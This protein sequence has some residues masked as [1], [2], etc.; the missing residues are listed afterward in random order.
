MTETAATQLRRILHLVPKIGDGRDH[1]LDALA[2][3]EGVST[4]ALLGDLQA[5]ATRLDEPGG[6][7]DPVQITIEPARD[8]VSVF[9]SHFLRPMRLTRAELCA[10]ELGLAMLRAERPAD[11]HAP[12]DAARARLRRVI[13][14]LPADDAADHAIEGATDDATN[15]VT[16]GVDRH[17]DAAAAGDAMHLAQLR[18]ALAKRR[19]V[20]L[21]YRKGDADAVDVRVVHT[22]ALVARRG[23]WY[24]VGHCERAE[25]LRNFRLDRVDEVETLDDGYAIPRDFSLDHLL[26]DGGLFHSE[27]SEPLRVRYS[28]RVARW[29]AERHDGTFGSDGSLVVEH[30]MADVSWAVRHILQY[31]P[32]AEV[33]GPE[34]VR[35][36]VRERLATLLHM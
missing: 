1:S 28:S 12:I 6:F 18:A 2:A 24:L 23:A 7:V 11:E 10:L 36:A 8:R 5:I 9:T 15:D 22:Y 17:A 32:D 3:S 34:R 35:N 26:G 4:K 21:A 30:P 27:A 31:G 13:S 19:K 14:R 16:D 25:G 33:L 20:R 29:I